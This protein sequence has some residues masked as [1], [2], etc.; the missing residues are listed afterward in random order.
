MVQRFALIFALTG[1]LATDT[2]QSQNVTF[3]HLTT[4]DGLPSNNIASI[5]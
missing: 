5:L 3:T 4:D 1:L 2:V